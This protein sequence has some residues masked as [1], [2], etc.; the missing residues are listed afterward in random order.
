MS[1]A[2]SKRRHIVVAGLAAGV[3]PWTGAQAQ[4]QEGYPSRPIRVLVG[5]PAG[6]GVDM[7]ARQLGEHIQ[8]LLGQPFVVENKPGANGT[9]A[10]HAVAGAAPDGYTL[11]MASAGE[12][13]ISPH[14]MRRLPYQPL[15][16]LQPVTLGTKVPNLLCVHPSLAAAS[17]AELIALARSRP[18]GLTYGSSG[19]GN[20]Q[21]LNGEL[22]NALA[23]TKI[24]H[25]PYKGAAPLIAEL[26]GGHIS[27][28]F[29]SVA[30]MFAHVKAGRLRP[31]AVTSRERVPAIPDIPAL[32]ETPALASYEL[33]NWFGLFAPAGVPAGVLAALNAAA[34]K[35]L[36]TPDLR[37]RL[38]DQ[39]GIVAPGSPDAFRELIAADSRRFA[40]IIRDVNIPM[41]G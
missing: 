31:I 30:A 6:G 19:V 35:A 5:H 27:M 38:I 16:D 21:H 15:R 1:K 33:N 8:P 4:G 14:L 36:S 24:V 37:Q 26:V 41:E 22:F 2:H 12:I 18:G 3:A 40:Q 10:A 13:A 20:L 9:I 7:L 32:A 28:G 25:V 34:V 23:G 17:T 29:T 11:L 39:G